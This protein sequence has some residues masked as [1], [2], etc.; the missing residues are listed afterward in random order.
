ML[1]SPKSLPVLCVGVESHQVNTKLKVTFNLVIFKV[2]FVPSKVSF[3]NES[4]LEHLGYITFGI[5]SVPVPL[6][7][8]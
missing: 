3:S 4:T 1:L 5:Y 2:T 6:S 8:S 7:L